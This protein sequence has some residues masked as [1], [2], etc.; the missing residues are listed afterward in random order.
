MFLFQFDE[1][2]GYPAG[3]GG[4]ADCF[5]VKMFNFIFWR[6]RY[7]TNLELIRIYFE[8]FAN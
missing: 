6:L 7:N 5:G 1:D 8:N 3:E 4:W 2:Y